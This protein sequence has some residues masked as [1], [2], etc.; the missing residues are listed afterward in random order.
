MVKPRGPQ[1]HHV[2]HV[3]GAVAPRGS[4]FCA[5]APATLPRHL[6]DVPTETLSRET[7]TPPPP[8]PPA[9]PPSHVPSLRIRLLRAPRRRGL[10]RICPFVSGFSGSAGC[11]PRSRVSCRSRCL[12]VLPLGDRTACHCTAGHIGLI[13]PC[14]R[15]PGAAPAF[16]LLGIKP[17]RTRVCESL[18]D[19]A[20]DSSRAGPRH[21][22]AGSH[23]D[24]VF[25]FFEEWLYCF[26]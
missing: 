6:S 15:G 4:L 21:G 2:N 8:P 9:R 7:R 10:P 26:P 11:L 14:P 20:S 18:R 16:W 3:H 25:R 13:P 12:K 22:I 19:P 17:L 5:A 23:G 24:C 1:I